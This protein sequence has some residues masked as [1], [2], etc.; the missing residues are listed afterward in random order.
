MINVDDA[1][2]ENTREHNPNWL[3]ILDH[4]QRVLI[5]SSSSSGKT[6][7]LL[8]LMRDQP[9]IFRIYF[10]TKDLFEAK[11]QLLINECKV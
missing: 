6:N 11:Y 10:Y 1:T 2:K 3:Q 5:I 9:N 4:L 7:A 8:N